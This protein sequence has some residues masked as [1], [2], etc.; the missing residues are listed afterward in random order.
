[1]TFTLNHEQARGMA[2]FFF[3]VAKAV[4]V[5]GMGLAAV[6]PIQAKLTVIFFAALATYLC[7]QLALSFLENVT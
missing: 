3:D 1:M 2:N 7:I 5:G 6:N 4:T